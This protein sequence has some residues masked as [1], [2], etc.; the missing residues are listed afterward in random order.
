MK[1]AN[2][3]TCFPKIEEKQVLITETAMIQ[4][5]I[6]ASRKLEMSKANRYHRYL[7]V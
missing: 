6:L 3:T 1:K 5:G 2:L 4:T 7:L